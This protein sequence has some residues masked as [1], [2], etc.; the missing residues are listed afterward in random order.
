[1]EVNY[2][3]KACDTY[4]CVNESDGVYYWCLLMPGVWKLQFAF[5]HQWGSACWRPVE[6]AEGLYLEAAEKLELF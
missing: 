3:L 5:G 4:S 2:H 1:M 6:V